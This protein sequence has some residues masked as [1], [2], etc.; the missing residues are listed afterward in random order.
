MSVQYGMNF[1]FPYISFTF[2]F[3][4]HL[5]YV[6]ILDLVYFMI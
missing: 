4:L 2:I 3:L 5:F 1:D 6:F